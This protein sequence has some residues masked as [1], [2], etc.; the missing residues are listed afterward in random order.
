MGIRMVSG[1]MI[2]GT[3]AGV[4]SMGTVQR[5]NE[6]ERWHADIGT[7]GVPHKLEEDGDADG[8]SPKPS[9]ESGCATSVLRRRERVSQRLSVTDLHYEG[10]PPEVRLHRWVLE[11]P[12]VAPV[13]RAKGTCRSVVAGWRR[14]GP[15]RYMVFA[16][17][18]AGS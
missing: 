18:S 4:W 11:V 6:G 15:S 1:E 9:W 7:W 16:R 3:S 5:N 8:P 17:R 13:A 12:G 2:V 10:R 14:R